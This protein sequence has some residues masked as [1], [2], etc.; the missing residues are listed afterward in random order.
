MMDLPGWAETRLGMLG[1]YVNGRGFKSSEWSDSGLPI[2]RIQNLTGSSSTVNYYSGVV[3]DR[4]IVEPGDLL[5]SWAATLGAYF[6]PGPRAVL[7]QHIFRVESYINKNFHKY[8]VDNALRELMTKTHGSGMV[9]I[10]RKPFDET[11]VLLPP[12]AEQGRIVAAIEEQFS[13]LD[14][15]VTALERARQNLKYMRSALLQAA[16]TGQLVSDPGRQWERRLLPT[17]GTLDRG[18]SRHRPR[19]APELYGGPYPFIQ[20]GDVAAATPWIRSYSQ[21]YSEDGLAQS[22]LWP[23]GTLCITIAANIARTGILAFDACFPDS[24]VG[25]VPDDGLTAARWVELIVRHMQ[26]RLER[27]APATAQKNINLAVLRALEIPY[28]DM[29][30]QAKVVE[31]YDRHMSLIASL[32]EAIDTAVRQSHRL[33][34]AIL[35]IALS[36]KLTPQEPSDEPASVLL[37]R[38]AVERTQSNG[39]APTLTRNA[40]LLQQKVKA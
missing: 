1:R 4:Y 29:R 21:A 36:G 40:H 32:D 31:E 3:E 10:T 30:Y 33:R 8:L 16:V 39:H 9:H 15:G 20:T 13:R 24:V 12:L 25:F 6:W 11:P 23:S 2:I 27:L 34:A 28:P 7:N 19:N 35:T 18:K 22:R 37:E 38:I 5:I 17:L 26:S 14:V